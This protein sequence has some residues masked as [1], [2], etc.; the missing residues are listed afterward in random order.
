MRGLK[1]LLAFAALLS[2]LSGAG[3]PGRLSRAR[4]AS[5]LQQSAD[6]A[7]APAGS[8]SS[9]LSDAAYA[10]LVQR[11]HA[12][13]ANFYVYRDA[14]SPYNRGT[15]SGLFGAD[16]S[17]LDRV[18]VSPACVDENSPS[19][20]STDVNKLDR[21]HVNVLRVAFDPL[22]AGHFAGVN[23]QEPEAYVPADCD[24]QPATCK[25]YDLTGASS[26]VFDV[27]SPGGADVQFGVGGGMTGFFHIPASTTYSSVTI[28]LSTLSPAPNLSNV[29]ILFSVATN[30][31]NAP[32][33]CTVLLDNIRF[34]TGPNGPQE[35]AL[36]L[37]LAYQTFGVV[38]RSTPSGGRVP[39][40]PDQ[41]LRNLATVYGAALT[42]QALL[43]RG[44][45]ADLSAARAIAD[46]LVYVG[47]H[48][49][50]GDPLPAA[51]N[52][53]T[54]LHNG[55]ESGD[56]TLLNDQGPGQGQAGDPRL[57]GFTADCG[58]GGF[59]R[60]SDGATGGNNAFAMLALLAAY[61]QFGDIRYFD[62][63]RLIGF[64][65][66]G[67]LTDNT[68]TGYGGY[69]LG[70]PDEG[71]VPKTLIK[72]K[73]VENN[74]AIFAA[75]T[76]QAGLERAAG[77]P[78]D[79]DMWTARA[80][81]A[82]DFV[83]RMFDETNG[84]FNAG[85]VPPGTA[86]G[87]GVSPD[88]TTLRG[89]DVI[90]TADFLDANTLTTLALAP[91]PRYRNQINW[92]RPA[93]YVRGHFART[94]SAGGQG[95]SGFNIVQTPTAGPNG[96]AWEFT[97]QAVV[98][99]QFVDSLYG[100]DNFHFDIPT[101]R[102]QL[103][104]AQLFAPFGDGLGLVAST[105][106]GGDALPPGEQ[107]LS[108]PFQCIPERVGLAATAWAVFA[109]Q[110]VNP[111]AAPG[112]DTAGLYNPSASGFFL[113]NAHAA[114]PADSTFQYGPA[115]TN[116]T[117]LSGDWNDDGFDT[118]GLYNPP[119]ATFF[120]KNTNAA[121]GADLTFQ[122]GPA[123]LGWL[124]LTGD[125]NGDGADTV[126]LYDPSTATF[127]L[128][129]TAA[130]GPADITFTFGPVNGA[131]TTPLVG[132]WD[133]DGVDTIGLYAAS[134][135]A[136]TF[137]LRNSNDTGF[138]NKTFIYG[139]AG[140]GWTPLSGDWNGDGADGVGLYDPSTG[141]FYLKNTNSGGAADLV[142]IYG[143]AGVGWK[144]LKGDWDGT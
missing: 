68:G 57:A 113:R 46:A 19:G 9:P 1:Q 124:P 2:L 3:Q 80:N 135:T 31:F 42:L 143:P 24:P 119:T 142:Y 121:G 38:P 81:V 129:N 49:N 72:S 84:R 63:S 17:D 56:L 98:L 100:E 114:G 110:R 93:Q 15:P 33:G 43:K 62:A 126:G 112:L 18:H 64:W 92:R 105:L 12:N 88:P 70:Y 53:T 78:A 138:A 132:D 6:S 73:S 52:G 125:W 16:A 108:T 85:T 51:P 67:S 79:A 141:T 75:F 22:P 65:I 71:V 115:G 61:K 4:A 27:R 136:S 28:P 101:Y 83:M 34:T 137:Y 82:G 59:C 69:Y 86:A 99:F 36:S 41:L 127:Y 14:D 48:D 123:G 29:H 11:A 91:A 7:A 25:G 144:P 5:A 10:L 106:Q 32:G 35:R 13:R 139:P 116:W 128:K 118:I 45:D 30:S 20:C 40:P 76:M 117:P 133:G 47:R 104:G 39:I 60:L 77:Y 44:A 95:F 54:G 130:A 90:N 122:Y 97:G 120:L 131:V 87:P 66:A 8:Q 58:S 94:V 21:A 96:I 55:Y 134:P 37:P 111:L 140:S 102:A 89:D 50:H 74:A 26:V 103:R 107:C 23:I 109:D